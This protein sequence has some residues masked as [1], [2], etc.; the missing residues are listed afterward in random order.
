MDSPY[1]RPGRRMEVE[2]VELEEEERSMKGWCHVRRRNG[3]EEKDVATVS[4]GWEEY[5]QKFPHMAHFLR[6]R[7]SRVERE[8]KEGSVEN[9][10]EMERKMRERASGAQKRE[11]EEWL[12]GGGGL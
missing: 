2:G 10:V 8:G 11:V 3:Q 6:Q 12:S 1:E 4:R 5:K 9:L 7:W